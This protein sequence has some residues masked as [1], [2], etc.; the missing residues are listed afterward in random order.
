MI[1][2]KPKNLDMEKIERPF[3]EHFT[4]DKAELNKG[5]TQ[6]TITPKRE[7]TKRHENNDIK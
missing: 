1:R 5:I 4:F 2:I 3:N 6:F 7:D